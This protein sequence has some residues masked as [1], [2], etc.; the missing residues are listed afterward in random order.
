MEKAILDL[1]DCKYLLEMHERIKT[2]L[3]FPSYYGRN[4]DAFWDSLTYESPVGFVEIHGEHTMPSK[5][6]QVL[7]TYC[8]IGAKLGL[9]G[10]FCHP[11]CAKSL[12]FPSYNSL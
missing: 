3:Q 9:R 2:A 6:L 5:L 4:W 1:T 10:V 8:Q 7:I 12:R 11:K